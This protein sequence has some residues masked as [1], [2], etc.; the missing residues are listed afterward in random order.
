MEFCRQLR[1]Y[2][3]YTLFFLVMALSTATTHLYI[4]NSTII[5]D[6]LIKFMQTDSPPLW[7]FYLS[8]SRCCPYY[9]SRCSYISSSDSLSPGIYIYRLSSTSV[10]HCL[11]F[12]KYTFTIGHS[13][14]NAIYQHIRKKAYFWH[15]ATTVR[16]RRTSSRL[17][18]GSTI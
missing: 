14:S 1:A 3:G 18:C 2:V 5:I 12:C 11:S 6:S 7:P 9:S 16:S 13:P 10:A 17:S 4:S 15:G 8:C